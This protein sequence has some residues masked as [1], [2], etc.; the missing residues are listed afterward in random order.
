MKLQGKRS[1]WQLVVMR[2][3]LEVAKGRLCAMQTLRNQ[4]V[5]S[6][7]FIALLVTV[8][9]NDFRAQPH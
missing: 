9:L 1:V 6:I 8:C 3:V 4:T 5:P 7:V 2:E